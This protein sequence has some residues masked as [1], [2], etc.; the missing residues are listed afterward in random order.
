MR[1]LNGRRRH[2]RSA[3]GRKEVCRW[4]IIT[5]SRDASL[6]G[7]RQIKFSLSLGEQEFVGM[8]IGAEQAFADALVE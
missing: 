3:S 5:A 4:F 7:E 8:S 2:A 6:R 1:L